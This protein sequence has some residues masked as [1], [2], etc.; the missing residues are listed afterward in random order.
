MY[1]IYH[2]A[3]NTPHVDFVKITVAI[4]LYIVTVPPE[5]LQKI[6]NVPINNERVDPFEIVYSS[7][8]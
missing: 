1:T 3:N 2:E 8:L 7:R 4:P 5:Y 6:L